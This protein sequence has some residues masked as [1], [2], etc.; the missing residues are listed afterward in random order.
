MR[1]ASASAWSSSAA[2]WSATPDLRACTSAPPR[3]SAETTS[4]VA[5]F[6][7]GGPPR[8]MVPCPLTMMRL[9]AH[10]RH[11]GAAGGAGAHHHGDLRNAERRQRRLVVEDAAEVL[12]VGKHL[13]LVRQVGAAG[14][15]QVDAGQ[16]VLAR[17][18]LGAQVLLHRHRIVGAALDGGVVAHDH[19]FAALDAAD[20]GD[21]AGAVDGVVV[22][23]EG[24]ERRQFQERAAGIDQAHHAVAR[25]KFAARHV[26]LADA[27]RPAGGGFGAARLQFVGQRAHARGVGGEFVGTV[28]MADLI[29]KAASPAAILRCDRREVNGSSRSPHTSMRGCGWAH[30]R[31]KP[32]SPPAL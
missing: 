3:S 6:T 9:V 15:D 25:Q 23:A 1:R 5:A 19:A 24:G 28:S 2:M 16:P 8:K 17:D 31:R 12:A 20:A 21:Q 14:V 29:G 7:S 27:R 13:G 18:L 4:P 11:V 10:R 32:P 26:A 22:H 30:S